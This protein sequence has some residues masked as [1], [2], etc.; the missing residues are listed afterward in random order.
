M[1]ENSV[2]TPIFNKKKIG[3]K[4]IPFLKKFLLPILKILGAPL[5][6]IDVLAGT[7]RATQPSCPI[8]KN[9]NITGRDLPCIEKHLGRTSDIMVTGHTHH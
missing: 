4:N 5:G 8:L 7:P 2:K 1:S 3:G 9:E 6:R